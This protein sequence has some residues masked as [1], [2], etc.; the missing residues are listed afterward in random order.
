MNEFVSCG[1]MI[2]IIGTFVGGI[3]A[4]IF[5]LKGKKDDK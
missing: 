1:A 3:I 4:G 2:V 5:Y